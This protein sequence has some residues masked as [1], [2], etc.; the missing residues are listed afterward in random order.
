MT[1]T[2]SAAPRRIE[3]L[4]LEDVHTAERNPRLHQSLDKVKASIRKYGF[5]EGAVHDARTGR[6]IAG[7]GRKQALQEMEAAGEDVPDGVVVDDQGRWLMPVQ[8]GWS[9]ADDEAAEALLVALNR[10]TE[11]GGWERGQLATMLD[12]LRERSPQDFDI[13]DFSHADVD[14]MLAEL[15]EAQYQG[16]GDPEDLDDAPKRPNPEDAI[17]VEGDVWLL[18]RHRLAV[19]DGTALSVVERALGGDHA[20]MVFTDPPYG[21]SYEGQNGMKII[22]DDLKADALGR[23]LVGSFRV[24]REVLK[25]G[26]VFYICAPSGRLETTFRNALEDVGLELRQQLVWMKDSLVLGRWDYQSQH[27]TMLY[28]WQLD[29]EPPVPPHFEPEHDN[30]LY[31]WNAG[32]AHQFEGGRK[33]TTIWLYPKPRRS[34]LHPTMK[35]VALVRRAIVNSSSPGERAGRVLD[36]FGGSGST[37][38]AC[39]TSERWASLVE[40][41][42]TYADVICRR[43]QQH[44]GVV[45]V[46]ERTGERVSFVGS[47]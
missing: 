10:L 35:P 18:G 13:T 31:G 21:V 11:T 43:F 14:G 33:Q 47:A 38:I 6:I 24:M 46:N 26:G 4:L 15:A 25:P 3:Y 19:G 29:G 41:D 36:L 9:S 27:E 17:S 30:L 20:Q 34:D 12:E 28:G 32:A 45:P 5:V 16:G 22:N 23:L 1:A 8:H 44:T 37:L 7:H 42:P 2:P 40:L 39:E